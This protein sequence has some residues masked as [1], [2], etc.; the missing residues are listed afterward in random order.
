[1]KCSG[2]GKTS[3]TKPFDYCCYCGSV[4]CGIH[5]YDMENVER[6][7]VIEGKYPQP[8]SSWFRIKKFI[9]STLQ[10]EV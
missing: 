5:R 1:M 7:V 6:T 2:C 8:A 3:N 10:E 9:E 4:M